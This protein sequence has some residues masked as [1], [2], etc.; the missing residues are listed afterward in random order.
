M[1]F[2][3][4]LILISASF[5]SAQSISELIRQDTSLSQV[6]AVISQNPDW[7]DTSKQISVFVPVNSATAP[8]GKRAGSITIPS[9]LNY[10]QRP[11]YRIFSDTGVSVVY[12]TF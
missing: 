6:A 4:S 11:N 8:S 7:S 3:A 1:L 5:I 12:G 9:Y 10:R 2:S